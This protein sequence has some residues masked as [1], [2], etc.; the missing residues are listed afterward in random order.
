MA[1]AR[2]G[3]KGRGAPAGG[4]KSSGRR[5]RGKGQSQGEGVGCVLCATETPAVVAAVGKAWN[6]GKLADHIASDLG[7]TS[8]IVDVHIHRCL[9]SSTFSRYSRV[10]CAFDRLWQAIDLAHRTYMSDP[11]MYNG[12]S[13]QGLLKQLRALMV[14]LDNVQNANELADDITQYALN[15]LVT[16]L[17]NALISEAGSLKE[18]L[19]ARYDEVEAERLVGDLLRRVAQHFTEASRTAHERI[20]D[21]LSARDRNR[22]KAAGGPGRPSKPRGKHA[23]LRAVS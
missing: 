13:Y 11:S 16:S 5:E 17:T 6:S 18:D 3:S 8:T 2:H 22:T 10:A 14:D 21:T 12:T 19:T 7:L 15:P 9:M 23:N 1:F 20:L 4:E